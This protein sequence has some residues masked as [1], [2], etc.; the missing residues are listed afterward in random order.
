MAKATL[1]PAQA[2]RYCPYTARSFKLDGCGTV[3][4]SQC[5]NFILAFSSLY[6]SI[7]QLT[8][9]F[10]DSLCNHMFLLR[11]KVAKLNDQVI[12]IYIYHM[13]PSFACF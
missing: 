8:V 11:I 1:F 5:V 13:I 9:H 6:Y 12:D 3:K 7:T 2:L 10:K 4:H